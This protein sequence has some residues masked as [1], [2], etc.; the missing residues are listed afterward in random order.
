VSNPTRHSQ[1]LCT[2]DWR[3]KSTCPTVR[4][5]PNFVSQPLR[6]PPHAAWGCPPPS[7][8][9]PRMKGAQTPGSMLRQ[10]HHITCAGTASGSYHHH[11]H[12]RANIRKTLVWF[13]QHA[14]WSQNRMVPLHS[15]RCTA[16]ANPVRLRIIRGFSSTESPQKDA[17]PAPIPSASAAQPDGDPDL[18][19]M[20][21]A[22]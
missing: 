21:K 9:S 22:C 13:C 12:R 19:N 20:C 7:K 14:A 8:A 18:K 5:P 6:S 17:Y 10:M 16:T 3:S 11:R 1:P 4:I 15:A 2:A